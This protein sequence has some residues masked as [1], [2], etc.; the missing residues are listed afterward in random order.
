MTTETFMPAFWPSPGAQSKPE[1]KILK[2]EFGDGYTQPTPDGLNHIRQVLTLTWELLEADEKAQ[3]VRFFE[4]HGGTKPFYFAMPGEFQMENLA[5]E[6][7]QDGEYAARHALL[8]GQ[9]PAAWT[10]ENWSVTARAAQMFDI[11][12]TLRQ[13]FTAAP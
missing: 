7:P 13:S 2:A 12:A 1:L 3:I 8:N 4:D 6:T 11:T 9:Q 10:C 5:C